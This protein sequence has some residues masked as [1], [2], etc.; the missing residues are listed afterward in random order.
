M[1]GAA[2]KPEP[3]MFH[4]AATQ[5]G[6]SRPLAIGDRLDTDLQ[7]ARAA[8]MPGLL[9]LTGV[10]SARDAVLAPPEQ[11]PAFIGEDLR[12]LAQAQPTPILNGSTWAVGEARASV[13]KNTLHVEGPPGIDRVRAACA[14]AWWSSDRGEPVDGGKLPD[15]GVSS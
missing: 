2:G 12:T 14:A 10:S 9:V 3:T 7:G 1:P 4:L 13:A 8:D 15:L 6:A 5:A 11:R